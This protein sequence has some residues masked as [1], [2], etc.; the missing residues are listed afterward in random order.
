MFRQSCAISA[1]LLALACSPAGAQDEPV[2]FRSDARLVVI[3]ATVVDAE[4]NLVT[5]LPET[6]FSIYENGVQ[7]EVKFFRHEDGPV[8][9]G[10]VIDDSGSMGPRRDKVA[11]AGLGFVRASHPDNEAFVLHFN[12]KSYL[13]TDFTNDTARLEQGLT[14]FDSRGT[15]SMRDALRLAMTHLEQRAREDKKVVLVVTDGEDNSSHTG[16]EYLVKMAQQTGVIVYPIGLL[17]E[18]DDAKAQRA[19]ADLEAVAR[20]TGGQAFFL[21]SVEEIDRTVRDIAR[22]IR[23]Q[24]TIAYTPSNPAL[25][26]TYRKLDVR[27]AAPAPVV[28]RARTGYWA[29][30]A[31]AAASTN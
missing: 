23:N 19:R 3:H 8:S 15:T 5:D 18:T 26:G 14:N 12:E 24:Y 11:A 2:V 16:R 10:L 9:V 31:V 7:Q 6:A 21:N 17:H 30:N 28:V 20:A 22:Q 4:G 29:G 27:V 1:F 25:D 13:D